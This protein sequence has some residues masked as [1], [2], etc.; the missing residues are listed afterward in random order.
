MIVLVAEDDASTRGMLSQYLKK[1]GLTVM[2]AVD[3]DEAAEILKQNQISIAVLDWMMPGLTGID[4]AQKI[5]AEHGPGYTYILMLTARDKAEDMLTGFEAGVDEYLQ[6]PI[7]LRELFARIKVGMRVVNL[8]QTI[9]EKQETL[10]D[11]I[12]IKNKFIGIAAHDLRNPVI[13]IRGF[14]E[15]LLKGK[16]NLSEEQKEFISIIHNTSDNMLALLNDLLDLSQIESGKLEINK[17]RSSLKSLIE[18]QVRLHRFHAEKKRISIHTDLKKLP[19]F[20]FDEQRMGQAVDNLLTNALKFSPPGTK[21]FLTLKKEKTNAIFGVQDE[22]PGIPA[23]EQPL[24]FNEFQRLS[25]RPTGG[26]SSTGLG[27]AITKRIV[28]THGGRI[29]VESHVGRGTTFS[30]IIPL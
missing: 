19:M 30:I 26:E 7:N 16:N 15:L 13:S 18:E 23:E 11:L 4:I 12:Q 29:A 8:E 2:T 10:Y 24:L 17:T 21:V 1:K 5:R 9:N 28:D 3:G 14:S 22:G 20:E 27:L 6:K 25:I